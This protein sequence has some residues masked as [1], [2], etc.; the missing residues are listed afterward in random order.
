MMGTRRHEPTRENGTRLN[1]DEAISF[2]CQSIGHFASSHSLTNAPDGFG[3]G[4][5]EVQMISSVKPFITNSAELS[6]LQHS[7]A[8]LLSM[9][10]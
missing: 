3:D 5:A 9:L 7:S 1:E 8:P 6:Y 4:A 2:H 10:E